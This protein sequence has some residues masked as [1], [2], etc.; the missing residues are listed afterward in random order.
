[1]DTKAEGFSVVAAEVHG[2][3]T[4]FKMPKRAKG[5]QH[6]GISRAAVAPCCRGLKVT[7]FWFVV[8]TQTLEKGC[9]STN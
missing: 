5:M 9:T 2:R 7:L 6:K 3:L 4:I 8:A 1:M